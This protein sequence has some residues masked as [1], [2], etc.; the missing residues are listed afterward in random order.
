VPA[1]RRGVSKG[2]GVRG[3]GGG[4]GCENES[5]RF[6]KAAFVVVEEALEQR[7]G[8]LCNLSVSIDKLNIWRFQREVLR[9]RHALASSSSAAAEREQEDTFLRS[10]LIS[11]NP[12]GAGGL[13]SKLL[14]IA[15][16][17]LWA[18]LTERYRM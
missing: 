3:G 1:G 9:R 8:V 4:G 10:Y 5:G 12:E 6:R 7:H 11:R 2:L 15:N 13:G 14:G 16:V 17:Y 18:L